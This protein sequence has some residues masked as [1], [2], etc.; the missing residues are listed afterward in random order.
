MIQSKA[1]SKLPV[2]SYSSRVE[3][4]STHFKT[5]ICRT[6][7]QQPQELLHGQTFRIQLALYFD[8]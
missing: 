8:A 2:V 3:V 6:P 1:D 5:A 7:R 4:D